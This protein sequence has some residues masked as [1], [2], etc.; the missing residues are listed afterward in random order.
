MNPLSHTP[1]ESFQTDTPS[2]D[3]SASTPLSEEL[4]GF[5]RREVRPGETFFACDVKA[6]EGFYKEGGRPGLC[7]PFGHHISSH[8]IEAAFNGQPIVLENGIV[9]SNGTILLLKDGT[10][11]P[12]CSSVPSGRQVLSDTYSPDGYIAARRPDVDA[13]AE[14]IRQHGGPSWPWNATSDDYHQHG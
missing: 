5:E 4:A 7:G 9:I 2:V 1:D 13:R 10:T 8:Q 6:I 14:N 11:V 3:P 12:N